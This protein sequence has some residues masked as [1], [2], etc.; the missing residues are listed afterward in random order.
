MKVRVSNR[1]IVRKNR[2]TEDDCTVRDSIRF[3]SLPYLSAEKEWIV[4]TLRYVTETAGSESLLYTV[5]KRHA[6]SS[7]SETVIPCGTDHYG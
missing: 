5:T 6:R 3:P 4:P 2:V 1:K 7:T